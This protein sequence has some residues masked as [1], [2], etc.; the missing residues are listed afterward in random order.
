MIKDHNLRLTESLI[1]LPV[2]Q[3]VIVPSILRIDYREK[4]IDKNKLSMITRSER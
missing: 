2:R 1:I 3:E 4:S